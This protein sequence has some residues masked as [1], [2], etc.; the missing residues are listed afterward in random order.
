MPVHT[1]NTNFISHRLVR[2]SEFIDSVHSILRCI[3][4]SLRSSAFASYTRNWRV[5]VCVCLEGQCMAPVCVLN[6]IRFCILRDFFVYLNLFVGHPFNVR[7]WSSTFSHVN[8]I[9]I[10]KKKQISAHRWS[11]TWMG[12]WRCAE[13]SLVWITSYKWAHSLLSAG[14]INRFSY[15]L[16]W[17]SPSTN[18]HK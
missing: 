4:V 7:R 3:F 2:V 13:N 17:R 5:C 11:V 8:K 12:F 15:W 16:R 14:V 6:M 1:E 18:L 9:K 10:K